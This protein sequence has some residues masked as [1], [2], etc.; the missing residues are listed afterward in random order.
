[1]GLRIIDQTG[2]RVISQEYRRPGYS[3]KDGGP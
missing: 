3:K 2:K 1:M